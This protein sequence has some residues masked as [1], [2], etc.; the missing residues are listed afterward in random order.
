MILQFMA[1]TNVFVKD[2]FISCREY[3]GRVWAEDAG[4][5]SPGPDPRVWVPKSGSMGQAVG[6]RVPRSGSPGPGPG[7]KIVQGSNIP[8]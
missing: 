6:V 1:R 4:S 8:F 5:G 3:S 7:S 2:I